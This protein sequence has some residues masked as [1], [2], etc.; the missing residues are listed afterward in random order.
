MARQPVCSEQD[1]SRTIAF[2][3]EAANY[4]A[5]CHDVAVI[6]THAAMVFLAGTEVY[7]IKKAVTYSYLDFSTLAKRKAVCL[8]ELEINQPHAPDIYLDVTP[9]CRLD[10]G[11]L[12]IGQGGTP[13]E[14]AV[15]M[16]R[17]DDDAL[18]A[19]AVRHD[20]PELPFY[21]DLAD[22]I[23]EFHRAAPA[24]RDDHG[25]DRIDGIIDQLCRSFEQS[26]DVIEPSRCS[27]FHD[28]VARQAHNIRHRL[29]QRGRRGLVR[30][31]HGDLHL[32]NIVVLNGKPVLFDAIEFNEE[33]ATTDVLYDLAFLI[34]DLESRHMRTAANRVLN[35]Y[36]LKSADTSNIAGLQ[37]MPLFLACRA[38]IRAMVAIVRM[39][40]ATEEA[41]HQ[42][43]RRE[44]L[45]YFSLALESLKER[46]KRLVCVGGLSG[47]G[48]TTVARLMAPV[49]G[50]APGALHLRSDVERKSLFGVAET[51]RLDPSA[52]RTDVS[53][54]VYSR[55]M[56]KAELALR[57][58]TSVIIDAV[59]LNVE[60]RNTA[61]QIAR[62]NNAS[63]A[64][65]WLEAGEDAL[66]ERI[67]RR[68]GDASDATVDV[69][70]GQQKKSAGSAGWQPVAADGTPEETMQ[71]CLH[72]VQLNGDSP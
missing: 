31:C 67:K 42:S 53:R 63:F 57:A 52:Y 46:P 65:L 21:D 56:R 23:I 48:K 18:L 7:K 49:I 37:A 11:S 28:L 69:L 41:A 13:V 17:F 44:A 38:A 24:I 51:I 3:G 2:L 36:V 16:R 72:A 59:F 9:I 50:D 34:M 27:D 26:C 70:H 15:H 32:K 43:A 1:Q 68:R 20:G 12:H 47:T 45:E 19:N 6:E 35:H 71:H 40:Q 33:I 61:E 58:G 10:D 8:R 5:P 25:A 29:V 14:W 22:E 66:V 62:R 4:P 54:K 60:E 39:R 64:G 55:L 30:R